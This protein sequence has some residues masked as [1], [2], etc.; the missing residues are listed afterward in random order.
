V[1]TLL[2]ALV[3]F[4]AGLAVAFVV[5]SRTGVPIPVAPS[6]VPDSARGAWT[7]FTTRMTALGDRIVAPD[8]PSEE[9]DRVRL[10]RHLIGVMIEGLQWHVSHGDVAHP[11]LMAANS[12]FQQWGGPNADNVYYRA[13][14]DPDFQYRL[15][16]NLSGID[17]V[18]ISL[19][20]GDM[21]MGA[22][23]TSRNVD[24][25]DLEIAQDGSFALSIGGG[26][27]PGPWLAMQ[28]SHRILS[29]RVYIDDWATQ[30]PPRLLLERVGLEGTAP[31]QM[32]D[33]ELARRI[34]RAGD[35]IE[36]NVLFWNAWLN[37][38]LALIPSNTSLPAARVSGGSDSLFYGGIAYELAKDE[39]LL[40]EGPMVEGRYWAF[41]R[42]ALGSFDTNYI[43]YVTSLNH[44]Q[45]RP[46][47]DG[48]FRLVL[49]HEDPGVANWIS[50]E[51][52]SKGL[53]T[54]RWIGVKERPTVETRKIRLEDLRDALPAD[55]PRVS[56]IERREQIAIRQRQGAWRR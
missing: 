26:E 37:Q 14:L 20:T 55:T 31:P 21:H 17:H 9:A 38:R 46:D 30:R 10:Q 19:S 16:G 27:V 56:P 25:P 48:R 42:S 22:F 2:I 45:I 4:A 23:E 24:I 41:Q 36:S 3:S 12:Q 49:A 5:L 34:T 29:V 13:Q 6:P 1:R 11:I 8:F 7:E 18:A 39:A 44:R 28:P 47:R 53:V 33:A 50:T 32:D 35:W 15:S 52:E 54:H 40:I 51:G 43:D